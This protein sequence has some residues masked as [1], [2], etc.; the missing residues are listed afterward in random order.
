MSVPGCHTDNEFNEAWCFIDNAGIV[1]GACTFFLITTQGEIQSGDD[2]Q[3]TALQEDVRQAL[4]ELEKDSTQQRNIPWIK[5]SSTKNKSLCFLPLSNASEEYQ[6]LVLLVEDCQKDEKEIHA[7]YYQLLYLFKESQ[8]QALQSKLAVAETW[9]QDELDEIARVQQLML[10]DKDL[11]L[12]GVELAFTYRAMKGAGGDY[13]DI[14]DLT[15]LTPNGEHDIGIIVAD[16]SG[17]GPA[18][19]VETAMIDAILRTFIP[20]DLNGPNAEVLSYINRHFFTRNVRGNFLTATTFRYSTEQQTLSYANAGHPHAYLKKRDQLIALDQGGIP[21]GVLKE[22]EWLTYKVNV[23]KGDTLFIYTDVVVETK[24]KQGEQF[25]FERLAQVLA[26]SSSAPKQLL[27]ELEHAMN[28]FCGCTKYQ[29]DL[30]MCAI[31]FL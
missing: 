5:S 16:V 3:K 31:Q 20:R 26:A 11:T 22:Q 2:S 9:I 19:A 21:I 29:D 1:F 17:H 8:Y 27:A 7:K 4:S 25:G 23:D 15:R 28:E 13:L 14:A 18:A 6:Y 10:P 24:N 30:T 12:P